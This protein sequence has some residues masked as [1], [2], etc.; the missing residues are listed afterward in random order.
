MV[1]ECMYSNVKN[2]RFNDIFG[3]ESKS[4]SHNPYRLRES[5]FK[6]KQRRYDLENH[7]IKY[8]P[9][10]IPI[11][12]VKY[13]IVTNINKFGM[14]KHRDMVI[15]SIDEVDMV[16]VKQEEPECN[17]SPVNESE[18]AQ[19]P[20][21]QDMNNDYSFNDSI[22][23]DNRGMKIE[24]ICNPATP[25]KQPIDE[26]QEVDADIDSGMDRDSKYSTSNSEKSV[27]EN[28]NFTI[29][30]SFSKSRKNQV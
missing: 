26:E 4:I 15:N 17:D 21:T 22:S 3:N 10:P 14:N 16:D 9:P 20:D 29:N 19:A 25:T 7:V 1:D 6:R 8:K 27:N 2:R 30:I 12:T 24:S 11:I 5:R 13:P 28:S 18:F 23:T